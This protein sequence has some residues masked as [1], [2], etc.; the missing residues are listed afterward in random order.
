MIIQFAFQYQTELK[1]GMPVTIHFTT[2]E[3]IEG[4]AD[5]GNR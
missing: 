3:F 5:A 2:G 1:F 4:I